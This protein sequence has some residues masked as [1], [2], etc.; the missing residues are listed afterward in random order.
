MSHEHHFISNHW[1]ID[2]LFNK[3][4]SL[5]SKEY[6][7]SMTRTQF[8]L[9]ISEVLLYSGDSCTGNAKEIHN[10]IEFKNCST[11]CSGFLE[12]RNGQSSMCDQWFPL[13]YWWLVDSQGL[14]QEFKIRP[15]CVDIILIAIN[16]SINPS[17]P[18]VNEFIPSINISPVTGLSSD[19]RSIPL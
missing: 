11:V 2:C 4:S 10:F 15:F 13:N 19:Q 9:I 6:Q 1:L 3:L 12:K 18:G 5:T 14:C 8:W 7:S 17:I 16:R